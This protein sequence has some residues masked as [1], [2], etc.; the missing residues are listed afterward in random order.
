MIRLIG[1]GQG[2]LRI[3]KARLTQP[4]LQCLAIELRALAIET[5][6]DRDD[7]QNDAIEAEGTFDIVDDDKARTMPWIDGDTCSA[8]SGTT[9]QA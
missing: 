1:A 3:G 9:G 5:T 6:V 8:P 7:I 4:D 2:E